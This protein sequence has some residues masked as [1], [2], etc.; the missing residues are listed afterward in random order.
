MNTELLSQAYKEWMETLGYNLSTIKGNYLKTRD[1]LQYLQT[2]H[3]TQLADITAN[4]IKAWYTTQKQRKS[5]QTGKLLSNRTLNHYQTNLR[6]FSSYLHQTEQGS[7][8][9]QLSSEP[10]QEHQRQ[11][12]TQAEIQDLYTAAENSF[13][14]LEN[15]ILLHLYY[16]CGLRRNEGIQLNKEDVQPEKGVLLVK[17]GKGYKSRIIPITESQII[18]FKQYLKK[19]ENDTEPAFL[20]GDTGKRM[21]K[22]CPNRRLKK[23]IQQ[24]NNY[25]L[26]S[27]TIGLHTLRHSIA[28]HLLQN[29]MEIE[30]ISKLLGHAFLDTTQI[31]THLMHND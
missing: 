6:L 13:N 29:G 8:D 3:I 21:Y 20:R 10:E 12:L 15:R 18:D 31:Y 17:H 5:K 23:L 1:F 22:D 25:P 9:I 30:L 27:K 16:G 28:T 7:L 19:L 2:Q 14:P 24:T 4:H 26:K 11:I